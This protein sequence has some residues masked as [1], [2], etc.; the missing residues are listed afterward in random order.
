L[1]YDL[2]GQWARDMNRYSAQR[3][4]QQLFDTCMTQ[5]GYNLVPTGE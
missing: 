5:R 1:N 4:Q 3:R 2:G